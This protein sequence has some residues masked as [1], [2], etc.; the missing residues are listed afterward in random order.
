MPDDF[1][2]AGKDGERAARLI[3]VSEVA[4]TALLNQLTRQ[5]IERLTAHGPMGLLT[6]GKL[7]TAS[8]MHAFT[9]QMAKVIAAGDLLGRVRVRER[10][11]KAEGAQGLHRF[12]D[13]ADV[14]LAFIPDGGSIPMLPPEEA[15]RYFA[16]LVP[17]LGVDPLHYGPAMFRTAF[18]MCVATETTLL[19]KVQGLLSQ[20]LAT[21]EDWRG[22]PFQI[23][24]LIYAAG[25]SP[26][27]AQYSSMVYRT[28]SMEAYNAG[29]TLELAHPDVKDFFPAWQYLGI[30]DGR[31]GE[32]HR[33]HFGLYFP[34]SLTFQF[35][36]GKRVFNCRCTPRPVDKYEW[37]NLQRQGARFS[38][39]QFANAI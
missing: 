24:Q 10:M 35:V 17:T 26:R 19:Q 4:G 38:N 30:R 6:T 31:E 5:A 32:D 18:T 1:A 12:A 14:P 8:E 16:N 15:A 36:R 9:E 7:F 13:S 11:A 29:L 28:N 23:D 37:V 39:V 2:L 33:P 20:Q 3:D 25:A 34:N 22:T 21:G 27:N